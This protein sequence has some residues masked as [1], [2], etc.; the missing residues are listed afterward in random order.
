MRFRKYGIIICLFICLFFLGEKIYLPYKLKE[1][2]GIKETMDN[3]REENLNKKENDLK[4]AY[5]FD[6][7]LKYHVEYSKVLFRDVYHFNNEITIYK[8]EKQGIKKENLVITKDG[9]IGVVV[10]TSPNSSLVRLLYN[11]DTSLSVK[12]NDSYGILKCRENKLVVEGINN[13][14]KIEVGDVITTSDISIYP[15]DVSIGRVKE[16]SYDKYEIEQLI[17]LEPF[18]NFSDLSYL[19]ILTE[20]RGEQ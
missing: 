8:G 7:Y 18:A 17:T 5:L 14:A 13:K 3:I 2:E 16:I 10:N 1:F 9:L 11:Q 4:E 20:L 12:I 6:D 19:G 15:E